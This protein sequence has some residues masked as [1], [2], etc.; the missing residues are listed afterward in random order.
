MKKNTV[1]GNWKMNTTL[2]D[3]INLINEIINKS[4][5]IKNTDLI[6]TPPYTHLSEFNKLLENSTIKLAAQNIADNEFGAFTGEVSAP[7]LKEIGVSKVI[8]GHSERRAYYHEGFDFLK[9]KVDC[10][11]SS[12]LGPIFC[13]GEILEQRKNNKQ[14]EVVKEQLFE[15]LFHLD[16]D[17]F[18]EVIIAYEPVWAIGTGVSAT[19]NEAQEMHAYIRSL[20]K[21]K[22]GSSM[23]ENT[24]ILYGGSCKP[25]NAKELFACPDI[26]GGL[27]GGA[28]LK[29]ADFIEIAKSF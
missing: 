8:I 15:S 11:I 26:D 24:T 22:Y 18:S 27:I 23:A 20:I 17:S 13:C 3:G 1:A 12:G 29:S 28:S 21:N 5:S 9:R 2:K 6:I 14:E 19:S 16:K 4:E 10:A 25:S 7:M